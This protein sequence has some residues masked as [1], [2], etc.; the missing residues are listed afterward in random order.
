MTTIITFEKPVTI[1]TSTTYFYKDYYKTFLKQGVPLKPGEPYLQ[2]EQSKLFK[3]TNKYDHSLL[4]CMCKS[5]WS[6]QTIKATS[7]R[8]RISLQKPL[9]TV[10]NYLF[11]GDGKLLSKAHSH[12]YS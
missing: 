7:Y 1:F 5:V 6:S 8:I 4:Q 3:I 2:Y 12:V 11:E 9:E 10:L